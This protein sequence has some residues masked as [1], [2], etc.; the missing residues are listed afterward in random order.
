LCSRE[1]NGLCNKACRSPARAIRAAISPAPTSAT[2]CWRP[3]CK[4]AWMAKGELWIISLPRGDG[5]PSS[6]SRCT[7]TTL[8]RPVRLVK[9]FGG[10]RILQSS[11][12]PPGAGLPK[13]GGSLFQQS[14][15][16]AGATHLNRR[17]RALL[18]APPASLTE[19]STFLWESLPGLALRGSSAFHFFAA[20][21]ERASY[22]RSLRKEPFHF[23]L[24]GDRDPGPSNPRRLA[25][26]ACLCG[27]TSA[28]ARSGLCAHMPGD[29]SAA[30]DR[31]F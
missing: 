25:S 17:K 13:T 27:L 5:A 29:L 21:E 2:S 7:S 1:C 6:R 11:A 18:L 30:P 15:G 8:A 10:A 24:G 23:S 20:E 22:E 3:R 31:G 16:W 19:E 26:L 12:P 28:A 14:I 4:S 9:D